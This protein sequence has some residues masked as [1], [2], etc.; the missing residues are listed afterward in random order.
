MSKGHTVAGWIVFA[1]AAAACEPRAERPAEADILAA[2]QAA[3]S[4]DQ[5]LRREIIDR[6]VREEDPVAVYLAYA[7][8]VPGWGTEISN[9]ARL[10]F[11]RT[12]LGV[13]NPASA[14][15]DWER[16]QMELFN[17]LA[18]SGQDP[19]SFEAAEI[20]QEGK[21]TVFRWLRP[22][23]MGEACLTCHGEALDSRIK[24]LLGQEYPL[25]EA[26]GYS[27][28]QLGGAYSVRKVLSI[29]GKPPPP[30]AT[31]PRPARPAGDAQLTQPAAVEGLQ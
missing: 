7:D 15:D 23:V 3:L 21:E 29:D 31:Q 6:I 30:Y 10:D 11:S 5:R 14:P 25:D 9:A 27:E 8:N 18:D 22:V 4:F 12:A 20:V 2:R 17:F 13:R 16:R 28:G 19:E 24:L 26:E 1:L